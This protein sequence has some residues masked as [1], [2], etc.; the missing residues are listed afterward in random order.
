M[1]VEVAIPVHINQTFTYCLPESLSHALPGCRV[2]VPF[3]NQLIT[4]TW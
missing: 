4:V 2:L 3:G 1:F